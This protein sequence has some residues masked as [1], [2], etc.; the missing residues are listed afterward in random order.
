[1]NR[2]VSVV[3]VLVVLAA[4]SWGQDDHNV[5]APALG[6]ELP[7]TV[8]LTPPMP[9]NNLVMPLGFSSEVPRSNFLTGSLQLGAAYD[10]NLF[11][12]PTGHVSDTSYLILPSLDIAQTRGRWKWDF[13][14]SAG[15]T[16]N[17]RITQRNQAAHN[18][19]LALAYRLTPHLAVQL[20]ENFEKTNTLFS[21]LLDSTPTAGPGPLQQPNS[22]VV[23]PWANRTGN[24]TGL[25]LTYQFSASSLVGAS[26]NFYFVNYDQPTGSFAQQ[27]GLIDS[28]SW[29]GDAFCA[30]RFSN[31][32]W[33]GVT[34]DLQRLL[35][36]L[37]YRTSVNRG[38]LFYSI[39]T[40]SQLTL[41]IWAGPE[42][43]TS[44]YALTPVPV[45]SMISQ[46]R[47]DVAGGAALS[48]QG[49]R[50]SFRVGYTRQTSD[51][52]GLT[53][54]VSLQQLSGQ[55]G[56][57]LSERWT[58]NMNI[59]YA[60]NDP[61]NNVGTQPL[62]RSW[63]GNAGLGYRLRDNLGL[64]FQYGRDQLRYE[65][66]TSPGSSSYRNRAWFSVNY[67]LSRP[68]GR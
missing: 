18:L 59:S 56:E 19:H 32:H 28:R 30:H 6:G 55:I 66:P 48:W 10:D 35:F 64:S 26:G 37:G 42:Y 16:I 54:A 29:G 43:T 23:T 4:T 40:E 17:Q 52:G 31:R 60:M 11:G 15:L 38:L 20:N 58:A 68:L 25:G 53:Q 63:L 24:T 22:S 7:Y 57:R 12:T 36:D 39:S 5:P 49:R 21:G 50:T 13:G 67:S 46:A 3:C 9:V 62:Y 65:Y 2:H 61:V 34:Y 27:S 8:V 45:Q 41:S 44:P 14:Y 51:G 33:V 47:W 1:M